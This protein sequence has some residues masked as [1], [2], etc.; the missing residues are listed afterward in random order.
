MVI[1]LVYVFE[2]IFCKLKPNH[3]D[4]ETM[5][6]RKRKSPNTFITCKNELVHNV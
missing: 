1:T 2:V 4:I 6:R 3:A 5:Q